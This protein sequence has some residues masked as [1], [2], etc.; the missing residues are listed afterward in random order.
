MSEVR[1]MRKTTKL[2]GL[3]AAAF[4][5]GGCAQTKTLEQL[6]LEASQTGDWSEV[7]KRERLIAKREARRGPSCPAGYIAYCQSE[8]GSQNCG[9]VT[10]QGMR[11]VFAGR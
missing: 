2:A 10:R 9:C 8:G 1:E 11:D 5:A 7:E 4:L 3:I 6:E